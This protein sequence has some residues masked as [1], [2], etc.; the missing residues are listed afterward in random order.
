MTPFEAVRRLI[1]LIAEGLADLLR[2]VNVGGFTL[3]SLVFAFMIISIVISV[4]VR[5][6]KS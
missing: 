6:G 3:L 5:S 1:V 2:S 4:F